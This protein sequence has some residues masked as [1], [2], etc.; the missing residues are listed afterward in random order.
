MTFWEKRPMILRSLLTIATPYQYF[1]CGEFAPRVGLL[2]GKN[3]KTSA[4]CWICYCSAVLQC[5]VVCCSVLQCVV[6]CCSV[7]QCVAVCCSV[8]QCVAVFC[9][10]LQC[11]AVCC[12]VCCSVLQCVA[13]CCSVLQSVAV[14]CSYCS[15]ALEKFCLYAC[16]IQKQHR[17][18]Q[19]K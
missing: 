9:S 4:H 1:V 10:V 3:L 17:K 16:Q 12:S 13:F 5:V 14:G 11:V 6:V 15:T 19:K 7:L 18:I 2:K 8:L